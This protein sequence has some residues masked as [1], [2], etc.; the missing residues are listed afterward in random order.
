MGYSYGDS[1]TK[2][3]F[4]GAKSWQLGWYAYKRHVEI[5]VSTTIRSY[6][7]RLEVVMLFSELNVQIVSLFFKPGLGNLSIYFGSRGRVSLC[8]E[9]G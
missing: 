5:D 9:K 2:M 7:G 6:Y 8:C 1:D 3:C 4:N